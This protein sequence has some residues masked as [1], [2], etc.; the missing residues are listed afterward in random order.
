MDGI[1]LMLECSG[2]DDVQNRFY[3]GWTCDPYIGAVLVFCPNGTIPICCYD[4]PGTVHDSNIAVIRNIYEKLE[5]I[6]NLT[7]GKCTVDS[8]F[9]RNTYPFLIKSRK[10]LPDLMTLKL[11]GMQLLC[12]NCQSGV[13]RPFKHHFLA[14]KIVLPLNTE[15]RGN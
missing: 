10:P 12:D 14:L 2:D 5:A 8:A 13:C 11:L 15:V 7:G 4:V 6:Y 3:N 1:K 9:T